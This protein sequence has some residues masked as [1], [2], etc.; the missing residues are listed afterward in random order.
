M[1]I[2]SV[3]QMRALEALHHLR[4]VRDRLPGVMLRDQRRLIAVGHAV[5]DAGVGAAGG[6]TGERVAAPV[7]D[8]GWD[9]EL[10]ELRS[11]VSRGRDRVDLADDPGGVCEGL[12]GQRQRG[13]VEKHLKP[14]GGRCGSWSIASSTRASLRPKPTRPP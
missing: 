5:D 2:V 6:R 11:A 10:A 3:A 14:L 9:L 8:G 13:R 12:A 1:K 4:L 7:Q